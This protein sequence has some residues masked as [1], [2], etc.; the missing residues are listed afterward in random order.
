RISRWNWNYTYVGGSNESTR[1]S[2][3][4]VEK[5]DWLS[6]TLSYQDGE[7]HDLIMWGQLTG[8]AGAALNSA[9]FGGA[10]VPF[11]DQD[12]DAT[13]EKAWPF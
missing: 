2:H 1:V 11:S 10:T 8:K 6:L 13:L 7:F 5:F 12:F 9:D 3:T 4:I